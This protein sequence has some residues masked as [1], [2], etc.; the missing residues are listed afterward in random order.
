MVKTKA[1]RA[2]LKRR[3]CLVLLGVTKLVGSTQKT[4]PGKWNN[5]VDSIKVSSQTLHLKLIEVD[6]KAANEF[7]DMEKRFKRR[8]GIG[9]FYDKR[10]LKIAKKRAEKLEI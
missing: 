10:D 2:N 4:V 9:K 1:L 6:G 3:I 7:Y 8:L 5:L